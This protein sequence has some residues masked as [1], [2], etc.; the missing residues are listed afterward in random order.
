MHQKKVTYL[1][2]KVP[3]RLIHPP[4]VFNKALGSEHSADK[5]VTS[6]KPPTSMPVP[7]APRRAA[8]PRRK[9][10]TPKSSDELPAPSQE[11]TVVPEANV[12]LPEST[13]NLLADVEGEKIEVPLDVDSEQV[14][15]TEPS[16]LI[17]D[18]TLELAKDSGLVT[19]RSTSPT[20]VKP[21]DHDDVPEDARAPS[22][23]KE[24][25]PVPS[26]PEEKLTELVEEG[27]KEIEERSGIDQPEQDLEE[28]LTEVSKEEEPT[29]PDTPVD[30]EDEVEV[31]TA[32]PD[33]AED[34]PEEQPEDEEEDEAIRRARITARLAKS[35]GFNPFAGGPP[36]R[37]PSESSLPERR[38]SVETPA[39]FKPTLHEEQEPPAQPLASS[40]VDSPD[41]KTGFPAAESNEEDKLF[42]TLKRVE[43]DS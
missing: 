14:P 4:S 26:L 11:E 12:P 25:Q 42:D 2:Q 6:H 39:P 21:G 13:S 7:A 10:E 37:K 8:P 31:L 41:D 43:G 23:P 9:K 28:P 17:K 20:L 30:K 33:V 29:R 22:V 3:D 15:T 38:T 27:Q 5:P 36:V 34:K 18:E 16:L 1:T 35:G 32:E 19:E 40:D 24:D